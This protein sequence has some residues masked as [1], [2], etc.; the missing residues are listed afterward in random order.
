MTQVEATAHSGPGYA[1]HPGYR[2]D[3]EVSPRLVRVV[4]AGK[5]IARTTEAL[6]VRETAH[7]PV[8]YFVQ[9]DV[10]MD[11][12]TAT[13]HSTHCPFKG[14]ASYRTITV[15]ERV[16]ENAVWSY[17]D[18][19]DEV[20]GLKDYVAFYWNEMDAWFEE[21]EEIFVH[22]R[23]PYKR[24]DAIPSTRTVEVV[25][26]GETVARSTSAH[27]LF[28]TGLPTRYYLPRSDVS[29][30]LLTPSQTQSRCPYKG[31]ASYHNVSVA[32]QTHDDLVWYYPDP[33]PECPKIKDLLCFFNEHVDA[34]YV[35]G[36][37]VPKVKTPWSPR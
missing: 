20:I 4:F 10:R 34:I 16:A 6:V 33:I 8:Y 14:D 31:V 26:G 23:D 12:M 13:D 17:P 9:A 36:E 7:T 25:V 5:E 28:E 30:A 2:V 18:P 37:E 3:F 35:D 15:G 22:P 1:T 27:F 32:D 24:I 11:L 21:G 29:V 19:Y